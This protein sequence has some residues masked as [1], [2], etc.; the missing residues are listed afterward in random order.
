[1]LISSICGYLAVIVSPISYTIVALIQPNYSLFNQSI[2]SLGE[3]GAPFS[4]YISIMFIIGGLMEA[5]LASG[6]YPAL[7]PNKLV[8]L[9]SLLIACAGI[10]NSSGS[11]IFPEGYEWTGSMHG[12]VSKIGVY[13]MMIAPF[14]FIIGLRRVEAWKDLRRITILVAILFMTGLALEMVVSYFQSGSGAVQRFEDFTYYFWIL[15]FAIKLTK[16]RAI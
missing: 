13:C 10:F 11:G 12:L 16:L 15:C 3:K 14:I 9:G 7:K 2:S 4:L 1:M 5:T 6:I 8:L